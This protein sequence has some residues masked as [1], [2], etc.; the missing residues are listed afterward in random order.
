[1]AT[2]NIEVRFTPAYH[3]ASNGAIEKRHQTI[4]N[5]LKAA[6]ID[7]GNHHGN[8]WN[9]ALPWVL[10]GKRVAVQPDLD[11]SAASLVFGKSLELPG[12]L[13][14]HPG[15]PLSNL[16]TKALLEEL[17][18]LENRKAHETSTITN[19]IDVVKTK[20]A[21]HV[22]VKVAEVRGLSPRF[23]G[24]YAIVARPSR[25]QV[26]VRVG[27][28]ANGS[29]RL[30]TFHWSSCKIAQMREGAAEGSRENLGRKPH[31][32]RSTPGE[33]LSDAT[34]FSKQTEKLPAKNKMST[35]PSAVTTSS[36]ALAMP[37]KIQTSKSTS[38]WT[39][40]FT[41]ETF[42]K[43]SPEVFKAAGSPDFVNTPSGRP[44]RSTRNQNPQYIDAITAA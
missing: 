30:L 22:Y 32:H 18:Q 25:S 6:L 37:A 15:P 2:F 10:L 27:S 3:A 1:M 21:T 24:P 12:Q 28:F 13:L 19:P 7:M 34:S 36:E 23:E 40:V 41:R 35:N 39:P 26:Q 9:K 33:Q 8:K 42:D 38:T 5:S 11:A 17:Y 16:E 29:P 31:P 14:G 4:K 20:N 44:V 43:W